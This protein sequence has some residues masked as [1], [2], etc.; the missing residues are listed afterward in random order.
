MT[1]FDQIRRH[2]R[3]GSA[4]EIEDRA[5]RQQQRPE[6]IE[7][8]FFNQSGASATFDPVRC[9]ALVEIDDPCGFFRCHW[10][11]HH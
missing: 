1:K 10:L 3:C 2:W 7:P 8:G 11:T 5:S 4:A 9:L 6:P